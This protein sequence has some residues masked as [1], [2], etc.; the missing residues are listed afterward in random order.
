M[1][2]NILSL[3]KT[4]IIAELSANHNG[5]IE[6]A[7]ET[8]RAMR[9]AGAD[10]VKLQTYTADTI[11]LDCD[12][13]YFQ[14]TQGTL[15]DGTTLHKLYG[16][17]Y[18]PWEWHAE[19]FELIDSLGMV[20]FSSP[21]DFSAVDFLENLNVPM[22]K[23]ASFEITD[24]NLIRYCAK[25]QKPMIISTGVATLT[26]IE[27]AIETCRSVGNNQITLLKCTSSYP[28]PL[29]EVNLLTISDMKRRFG[30]EV[31][32]SDHTMDTVAPVVAVTLGA[33]VIEKHFILD[34]ALGGVDSDFSLEPAEFAKMV[35]QVRQTEQMLGS[36]NY[37]LTP[38]T[39]KS[40]EFARSLFVAEDIA[41]GE[42]FTTK[43][44]RSVRPGFGLHPKHLDEIVG[45]KASKN[46]KKGKP[47]DWSM[48]G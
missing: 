41:I 5:S 37:E 22:Y 3:D 25:K 34:R 40:R 24:T 19:L 8:I 6:L 2:N 35:E 14:I 11:T 15:W 46:I 16:Q 20:Y 7:K 1:G 27:L 17:A 31:G 38:K 10:A 36:I 29:N 42:V 9:E 13:E 47:L 45:K 21:F 28:A 33:K 12:N 18:T 44:I 32:L 4:L 23:I 26:D 39:I 30:C 43:N 48:I